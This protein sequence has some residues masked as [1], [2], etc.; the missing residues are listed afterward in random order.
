MKLET[1]I[2]LSEIHSILHSVSIIIMDVDVLN[3]QQLLAISE[4]DEL[5]RVLN[6]RSQEEE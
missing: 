6:E 1:H 5:G 4:I 2:T 3:K